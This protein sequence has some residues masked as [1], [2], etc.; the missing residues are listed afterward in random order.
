[1]DIRYLDIENILA[2][3]LDQGSQNF[4]VLTYNDFC[5]HMLFIFSKRGISLIHP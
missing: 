2:P 3:S 1:M 5:E 4:F